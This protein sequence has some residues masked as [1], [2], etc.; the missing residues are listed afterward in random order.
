MIVVFLFVVFMMQKNRRIYKKCKLNDVLSCPQRN[1]SA[2]QQHHPP[3]QVS[4]Y[5]SYKKVFQP[6]EVP[7]DLLAGPFLVM[8]TYVNDPAP[9][10]LPV[11]P[12]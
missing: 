5:L 2:S 3:I 8:E 10:K 7:E 9:E 1:Q 6:S 11:N 12:C 4:G